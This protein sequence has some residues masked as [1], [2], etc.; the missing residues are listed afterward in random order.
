MFLSCL[1]KDGKEYASMKVCKFTSMQNKYANMQ[2]FKQILARVC[3]VPVG[4]RS[5]GRLAST[6]VATINVIIFSFFFSLLS[7]FL[8]EKTY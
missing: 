6:L 2:V 8:I 3:G 4:W 7:T 1:F 5:G